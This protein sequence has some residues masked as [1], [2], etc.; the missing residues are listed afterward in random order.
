MTRK[1][2]KQPRQGADRTRHDL[3]SQKKIEKYLDLLRKG[4]SPE[5]IAC[6][7]DSS[8][9][10]RYRKIKG[11]ILRAIAASPEFQAEQAEMAQGAMIMGVAPVAEAVVKRGK[12]GRVDAAKLIFEASG[13]H[14]PRV[15]H[16]H[17]GDISISLNMPRP[18]AVEND[19]V[20]ETP[21]QALEDGTIV[22][23]DVVEE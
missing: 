16:E 10:K 3:I 18:P 12:R 8:K 5:Q 6:K 20:G 9:G 1:P 22:D 21:A 14:N 19:I 17:S 13:F 23:A 7:L 2:A 15:K 4:Y 11:E